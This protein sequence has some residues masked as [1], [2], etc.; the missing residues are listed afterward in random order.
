MSGVLLKEN[1]T[2]YILLLLLSCKFC[3]ADV[4]LKHYIRIILQEL[5][6]LQKLL[7]TLFES[8]DVQTTKIET[9]KKKQGLEG[10]S[11]C[12]ALKIFQRGL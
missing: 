9:N 4:I 12:A 6:N 11:A 1:V 5:I 7:K 10:C 8:D 2:R 3:F